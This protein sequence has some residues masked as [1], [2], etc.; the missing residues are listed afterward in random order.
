MTQIF[1]I[2]GWVMY[3]LLL[4][5]ILSVAIS[6]ERAL[7]W[8]RTHSRNGLRRAAAMGRRAAARDHSGL[9]ALAEEERSIYGRF[10]QELLSKE[11]PGE[12]PTEAL[13]MAI[14][15]QLRRP[16][17]RRLVTLST[18]ITAAP[19]LGILGTVT[20]IIQSFRL[21][22]SAETISDPASVASGIAEA[23]YT[24]AFGL[25]VALITLFPYAVFRAHADRAFTRLELLGGL[26][27][28]VPS[29]ERA[30]AASET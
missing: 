28:D 3:P 22:G 30:S 17:E 23:L 20:G 1:H 11:R 25:I 21:L 14:I 2:G 9:R 19:M 18:I 26:V 29:R 12:R 13:A 16:I 8:T 4:L 24:T 7:F 15:E 6:L 10:V 27:T 5:S